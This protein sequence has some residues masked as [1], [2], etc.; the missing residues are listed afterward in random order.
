VWV[1][2]GEAAGDAVVAIFGTARVDGRV[3]GDVVAVGGSVVLG[4]HADVRGNAVAVGGS[5]ERDPG[6]RVDGD[7]SE[8]R[9]GAPAFGPFVRFRPWGGWHWLASPFGASTDLFASL[10][11]MSLVGLLAAMIVAVGG[12]PVRR[13]SRVIA[14][15]PWR[16]AFAGLAAQVFF[17]PVLVITVVVLAVSIIGIPLLLLVPFGLL[18]AV[19]ALF[20]GFTGAGCAI[21][22]VVRRRTRSHGQNLFVSLVI[23]L[24]VVWALTV[25]ARFVGLAGGPVRVALSVV[26]AAGFVIEYVAWT[27]GLGAVLLSRFGRKD[28]RGYVPPVPAGFDPGPPPAFDPMS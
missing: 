19:F 15:E 5:V 16:A 4:P 26:L 22:D 11:R 20:L 12:T 24:A 1:K 14:A 8:V 13:V 25:I 9:I 7:V 23:G 3:D 18:A 17:V 28:P 27:V 21:G 2:E 6:A 10:L